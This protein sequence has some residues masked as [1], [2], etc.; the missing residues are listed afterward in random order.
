MKSIYK[1][2]H[3]LAGAAALTLVGGCL[4]GPNYV[5]PPAPEAAKFKEAGDWKPAQPNDAASRGNWW[6]IFGSVW[7][8]KHDPIASN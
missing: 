3:V 2:V 7:S 1:Y 4:V 8:A 5:R 6:E